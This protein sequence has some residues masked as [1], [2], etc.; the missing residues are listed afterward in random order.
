MAL[1]SGGGLSYAEIGEKKDGG[2]TYQHEVTVK[3]TAVPHPDL[4]GKF[5]DLKRYILRS[6]GLDF[7]PGLIALADDKDVSVKRRNA[8]TALTDDL[9]E[10]GEGI[11]ERL[12]VTQVSISG[13]DEKPK[14]V[15]TA[16]I[17]TPLG[18]NVAMNS[19]LIPLTGT[20]LGFEGELFD[21]LEEMA[22]E[23]EEFKGGK[24][25]QL[26]MDFGGDGGE[27]EEETEDAPKAKSKKKEAA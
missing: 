5:A 11:H 4:T 27:E 24:H 2:H 16:K 10:I 22:E 19:P 7:I 13:T 17:R 21:L 12:E 15:L 23:V 25:A 18:G 26:S 20:K 8:V 6:M 9:T 1:I 14:V 3:S